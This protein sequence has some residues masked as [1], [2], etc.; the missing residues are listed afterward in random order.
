MYCSTCGAL[1]DSKLSYCQRCG[2][3]I[4]K[5]ATAATSPTNLKDLTIVTGGVGLGGLGI[6]LGL[7]AVLLN[8]NVDPTVLVILAALFLSAVFG[9]TFWMTRQTSRMFNA[10][11][12]PKEDFSEQSQLNSSGAAQITESR[13]PAASIIENTT[14]TLNEVLVERK[15]I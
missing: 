6:T 9:I 1:I 13:I 3:R 15:Q 5:A 8:Y 11:Q 12:F 2:M 4:V 10:S 7:V 14:R